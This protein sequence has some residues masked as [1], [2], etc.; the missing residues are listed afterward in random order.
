MP[1]AL[2]Y[3]FDTSSVVILILR[4][5]I[6]LLL[7]VIVPGRVYSLLV[8]HDE[9]VTVQ[10]LLIGLIV[11]FFGRLFLKNLEASRGTIAADAVMVEPGT[12]YGIRLHGPAG[13]FPL[14]GFTA[15]RVERVP[16]PAWTPGGPHERVSLAGKEGTPDILIAR[17]SD[18]AG[19]ALGRDL[20]AALSLPYQEDTAPY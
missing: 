13:R 2:P 20:A 14:R 19:R 5:V 1:V 18:D 7:V 4:G 12:L 15:V 10:L 11:I 3:R 9:V 17:T 16:P 8:S 6:A